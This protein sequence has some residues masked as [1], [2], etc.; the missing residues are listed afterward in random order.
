MKRRLFRISA[1]A[2]T[3]LFL[4]GFTGAYAADKSLRDEPYE[5]M[6]RVYEGDNYGV[7]FDLTASG[8]DAYDESGVCPVTVNRPGLL[9]VK[10][11]A[12]SS[13]DSEIKVTV[14]T[15]F[16]DG[17]AVHKSYVTEGTV[18]P[19]ETVN[20]IGGMDVLRGRTYYVG[21]RSSSRG[22]KAHINPFLITND[23]LT[24]R[25]GAL[26]NLP[27]REQG[28]KNTQLVRFTATKTGYVKADLKELGKKSADGYITLSIGLDVVLSDKL[29]YHYP[30][31]TDYVVFGVKEGKTYYLKC[32]LTG[33]DKD[34][35]YTY[36]VIWNNYSA[37]YRDNKKKADAKTLKRGADAI[38]CA[39]PATNK[40][41]EQWYKIKVTKK[42]KTVVKVNAVNV[43]SGSTKITFYYGKKKIK[44]KTV[45][46]GDVTAYKISYGGTKGKAKK[47]T[48]YMKITS[49]KHMS[50]MYKM[51]YAQ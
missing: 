14:A 8:S 2:V 44:T 46:N 24:L 48:Y 49:S 5:A 26:M 16:K 37:K 3:L 41:M 51:K 33:G 25:P 32:Y 9:F 19:G 1:L 18:A 29:K 50:G 17:N 34:H 6:T 47:G 4:L 7:G 10:V 42:R 30:S 38:S 11:K 20:F 31:N 23:I 28:A 13:N 45:P 15:E 36:N 43:K 40:E 21:I 22:D 39:R 35:G 27:G 12:D